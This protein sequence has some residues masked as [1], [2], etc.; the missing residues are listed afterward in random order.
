MK[1]FKELFL[2]E[3]ETDVYIHKATRKE[4]P[5]NPELNLKK[6]MFYALDSKTDEIIDKDK[7]VEK[8]KKRLN[9][10]KISFTIK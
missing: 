10:G 9:S 3:K 4:Y 1:S 5:K 2:N 7:D 8:L 6:N